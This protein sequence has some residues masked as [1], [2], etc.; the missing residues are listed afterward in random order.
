M[1]VDEADIE[2]AV[3]APE[4]G[5][6]LGIKIS[7]NPSG[8]GTVIT[9][10][11][12]GSVA[13][14]EPTIAVG[15]PIVKVNGVDVIDAVRARPPLCGLFCAARPWGLQPAYLR[16]CFVCGCMLRWCVGGAPSRI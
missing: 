4:P 5:E 16:L 1:S 8:G 13:H 12:E 2:H 14:R 9:T 7:A 11:D 10:V 3:L 15:R 6:R